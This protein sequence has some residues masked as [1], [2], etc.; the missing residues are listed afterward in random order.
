MFIVRVFEWED[1]LIKFWQSLKVDHLRKI[2]I[3]RRLIIE[4]EVHERLGP[5]EWQAECAEWLNYHKYHIHILI[6]LLVEQ[7]DLNTLLCL[8]INYHFACDQKQ[9][10]CVLRDHLDEQGKFFI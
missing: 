10:S 5:I 3:I 9:L 4:F 6:T 2:A 1:F 8:V 7:S